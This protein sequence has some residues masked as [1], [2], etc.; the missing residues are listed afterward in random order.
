VILFYFS[1]KILSKALVEA[2]DVF[3]VGIIVIFGPAIRGNFLAAL[4]RSV[5]VVSL[6][7]F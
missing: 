3:F 1:S 4:F 2:G 5:L 6:F 7:Y